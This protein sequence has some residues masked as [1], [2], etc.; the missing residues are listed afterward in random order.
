[1]HHNVNANGP[2][3]GLQ[4]SHTTTK[5]HSCTDNGT[6]IK[7]CAI[8]TWCCLDM[9]QQCIANYG[10]G[11]MQIDVGECH[12][13]SAKFWMSPNTRTL[14]SAPFHKFLVSYQGFFFSFLSI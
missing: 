10:M 13:R 9:K 1:M 14:V 5:T 11:R 12:A 8:I 4:I 7:N 2:T 3:P 6:H